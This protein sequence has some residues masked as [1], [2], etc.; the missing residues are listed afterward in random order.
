ME[1]S[2]VY[3]KIVSILLYIVGSVL[4]LFIGGDVLLILWS[5]N[6]TDY[7]ALSLLG[8]FFFLLAPLVVLG[9]SANAQFSEK[10]HH[11]ALILL[12]LAVLATYFCWGYKERLRGAA[13]I[14]TLTQ[15]SVFTPEVLQQ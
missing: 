2:N 5:L 4:A 11:K 3:K 12:V 13:V 1:S 7:S 6:F 14:D 9:F 10:K 8:I 15:P